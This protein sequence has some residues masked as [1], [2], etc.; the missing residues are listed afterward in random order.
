MLC[1]MHIRLS[2]L[3]WIFGLHNVT[4]EA[5]NVQVSCSFSKY[6]RLQ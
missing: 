3:E 5:V 2:T 6:K 4:L 1:S